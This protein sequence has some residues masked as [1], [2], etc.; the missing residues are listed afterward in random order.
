MGGDGGMAGRPKASVC[1]CFDHKPCF[2]AA[3]LSALHAETT[4]RAKEAREAR[5]AK[6]AA[7]ASGGSGAG[8]GD[9]AEQ[10]RAAKLQEEAVSGVEWSGAAR[11]G[12]PTGAWRA[13][14]RSDSR[15][16]L[17]LLLQDRLKRMTPEQRAKELERKE[18][19]QVCCVWWW[20]GG[21]GALYAG[22]CLVGGAALVWPLAAH[23]LP[24]LFSAQ[25]KRMLN[26][27][28]RKM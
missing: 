27:M 7:A 18:K 12:A 22:V 6:L 9:A 16:V 23:Q 14:T 10:R 20:W 24:A 4:K 8:G 5:S 28:T 17:L 13:Q 3:H 21:G 15:P 25:R 11:C 19:L 1:I 26:K 2:L